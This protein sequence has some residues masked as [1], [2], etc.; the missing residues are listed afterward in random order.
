MLTKPDLSDESILTC[1]RDSY[2]LRPAQVTFLPLGYENS[3]IYRVTGEDGTTYFLKL[4][5]EDF[6][7]ISVAVPAFLHRQGIRQ[8][9]S[10]LETSLHTLWLHE[11]GFHWILYPFFEGKTGFE[12]ALSK[13][14]WMELGQTIKMV[15]STSLPARL[16][17]RV[18]REGYSHGKRELVMSYLEQVK[19]NHFDDPMAAR[20]AGLLLEKQ[21]EIRCMVKRAEQLAQKL[22]NQ[23]LEP[24]LCHSDLHGRN[25]LVSAQDELVIID[26]DAPILAPK[27]RDLMFIG[28]GVG[29]IWNNDQEVEW[30]YEGY[31]WTEIDAVALS[32]Y[33][34]E[35]IIT[36]IADFS[37]QIFGLR[38]S[39]EDRQKCLRLDE[40]FGPGNVVE[41]AHTTF[42]KYFGKVIR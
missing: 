6:N 10:P 7:E 5:K 20:F 2:G 16:E 17:E 9:M 27:E 28:G 22:L 41:I 34:Y 11:R 33:R 21:D 36:D 35:R 30:F 40:Q 39:V 24:V 26:W 1:L 3:A 12:R 38:G 18:P 25:T 29:G 14:Q 15:H 37:G 13:A 31:G 4:I 32:Y 19:Q 8:V 23:G 42:G